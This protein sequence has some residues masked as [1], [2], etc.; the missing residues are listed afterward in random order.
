[1]AIFYSGVEPP[2]R[3]TAMTERHTI[4]LPGC[5]ASPLASYLKGLGLLRVLSRADPGL[6]A[7]WHATAYGVFAGPPTAEAVLRF[8]PE[9]ARW[10][11]EER[12]HPH[13]RGRFTDDDRYELTLPY[14]DPRE[15]VMDMAPTWRWWPRRGCGN[16]CTGGSRPPFV[17]MS[18]RVSAGENVAV[19][20]RRIHLVPARARSP[21]NTQTRESR[22]SVKLPKIRRR[23]ASLVLPREA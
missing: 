2:H 8:T 23:E 20:S 12:W 10:V 5:T 1:M 6:R 9:R 14:G 15:L 3:Q 17:S 21:D 18:R 19:L 7:A 11:A 13:Q 4:P 22:R 16:R